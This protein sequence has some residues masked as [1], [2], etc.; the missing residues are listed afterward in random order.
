MQVDPELEPVLKLIGDFLPLWEMPLE[1]ARMYRPEFDAAM[2]RKREEMQSVEDVTISGR[3]GNGILLRVYNP[4]D[5][6]R[7]PG[8]VVFYHGGGFVTGSVETYDSLCSMIASASG[9]RV[10]SVGYRLAPE[11]KFPAAPY[12]ALDSFRWVYENMHSSAFA[13]MGDSAG[14]NLAAV[15]AQEAKRAGQK[16][17]LQVLIYPL[18]TLDWKLPSAIEN[19]DAPTL[20]E[21]EM[22][23]YLSHYLSDQAEGRSLLASP[24]LLG[25]LSDVPPALIITAELDPL[26][27]H[28]EMYASAL[29]KSGVSVAGMRFTG[30]V[31]GFFGMSFSRSAKS[32][33]AVVASN[34]KS[35]LRG[36]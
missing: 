16:I 11:H 28:G 15:V 8:T 6:G 18:L 27:D 3:E 20:S 7:D 19:A 12:D 5:A 23:W 24:L 29:R 1:Q 31:H 36:D 33:L 17:A 4:Q 34:L 30:M 14:G 22:S 26:R 32:A 2:G 21:K 9:C 35:S 13:V 10:V 25:D